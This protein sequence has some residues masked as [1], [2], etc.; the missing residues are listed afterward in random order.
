MMAITTACG[1]SEAERL[2]RLQLARTENVG[3]VTF[4]QLLQRY[5]SADAALEALPELARRGGR[6]RPVRLCRREAATREMERLAEIGAQ[7]L[8]YGDGDFPPPL[9]AVSDAPPTLSLQGRRDLLDRPALAVVGARNASSSGRSLARHLARD[10]AAEGLLIIS[11]LARGIDAA[12]HEGALDDGTAAVLAGGIDCI[13]PPQNEALHQ[14]IADQGLLLAELAPGTEPQARHFPRRNRIISGLSRGVLVVEAAP[15][16]GSLITARLAAEQGREVLAVPGSPLDPRARGCNDLLRQGATLVETADDV[17][18]ALAGPLT[19][20]REAPPVNF[21]LPELE[22]TD[23]N[24]ADAA[25]REL[26]ELLS[27]TA[28]SVDELLRQCQF[29]GPTVSLA[30]LEMELAGLIER[31]PGNRVA[32]AAEPG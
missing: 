11:G 2:A 27:P 29:S 30:L 14:A 5:G 31:R 4:R 32:L 8:I 7:L 23:K 18:Q 26:R 15:R 9:A 25:H 17:L 13:Y 21:E 16:S 1:L 22:E 6:R 10:L 28:V 3:P 24:A 20:L 12:A 19:P